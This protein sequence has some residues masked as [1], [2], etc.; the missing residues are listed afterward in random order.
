MRLV[1]MR[2]EGSSGSGQHRAGQ[3]DPSSRAFGDFAGDPMGA[4]N[5]SDRV[6]TPHAIR[7]EPCAI[8]WINERSNATRGGRVG[9]ARSATPPHVAGGSGGS[10]TDQSASFWRRHRRATA[11]GVT[12]LFAVDF[13]YVVVPRGGPTARASGRP[14]A[15]AVSPR[16]RRRFTTGSLAAIGM[17]KRRDPAVLGALA[18]WGLDIAV[19]WASFRAFGHSPPGAVLVMGYYVGQL[20]NV[21]PLPGGI[22]GCRGRH[23]RRVPSV[24]RPASP[25]RAR[26]ARV[27]HDLILAADGPRR[28]RALAAA[29]TFQASG[30]ANHAN[31]VMTTHPVV[32]K[33][34]AMGL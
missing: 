12:F 18:G 34:C 4:R 7:R 24:R 32:T 16:C 9:D 21:L 29:E 5:H 2:I 14:P 13:F 1:A 15:G 10:T 23:D 8:P 19:L 28:D 25:G 26:R 30:R 33:D 22:G 17:V 6:T 11:S 27:P 3:C 31:R 20:A